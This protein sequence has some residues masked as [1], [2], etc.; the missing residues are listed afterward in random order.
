MPRLFKRP[1]DVT[2]QLLQFIRRQDSTLK[3]GLME[4]GEGG[5]GRKRLGKGRL[6]RQP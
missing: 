6:C 4:Q 3:G 5:E 1:P 2:I